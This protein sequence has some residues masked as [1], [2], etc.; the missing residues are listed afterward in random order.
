MRQNIEKQIKEEEQKVQDFQNPHLCQDIDE[1]RDKYLVDI[2]N[3]NDV[4]E[5][6]EAG[7]DEQKHRKEIEYHAAQI[8]KNL[9]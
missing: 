4:Y 8:T 3:S 1:L 6:I 5:H 7:I 2:L 9:A